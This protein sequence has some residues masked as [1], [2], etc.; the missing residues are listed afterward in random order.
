MNLRKFALVCF[1]AGL[2][3]MVSGCSKQD[4]LAKFQ[5]FRAEE[6][7]SKAVLLKEKK[8]PHDQRVPLYAKACN[9]FKDAFDTDPGVFTVNRIEEAMDA[10]WRAGNKE[11]EELFRIFEAQ[12]AQAHPQE[13]EHGDSG[14]AMMEMG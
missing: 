6:E 1:F 10:C 8:V 3:F 9:F 14:I 12:Y 2:C 7:L 4:I 13:Y 11:N 5:V